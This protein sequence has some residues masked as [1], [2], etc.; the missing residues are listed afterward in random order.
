[1]SFSARQ[2]SERL[3]E[4][5]LLARF[6]AGPVRVHVY[7]EDARLLVPMC[8]VEG[9]EDPRSGGGGLVAQLTVCWLVSSIAGKPEELLYYYQGWSQPLRPGLNH[10]QSALVDLQIMLRTVGQPEAAFGFDT[11]TSAGLLFVNSNMGVE[12]AEQLARFDESSAEG[13]ELFRQM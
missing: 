8:S 11:Y 13:R 7:E 10:A 4:R 12:L 1:M 5:P 6:M 9:D 2:L 3:A